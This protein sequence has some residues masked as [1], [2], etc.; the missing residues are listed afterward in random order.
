[1][2]ALIITPY[3]GDGQ[4]IETGYRPLLGDFIPAQGWNDATGNPLTGG[5]PSVNL[6]V[7]EADVTAQQL[8]TIKSDNRFFVLEPGPGYNG[9]ALTNWLNGKG[10]SA[11]GVQ[12][13]DAGEVARDKVISY[14]RSVQ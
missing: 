8:S 11:A 6:L 7:V 14:L 9:N 3:T 1:M 12:Q 13:G 2:I 10:A 5:I 4:S